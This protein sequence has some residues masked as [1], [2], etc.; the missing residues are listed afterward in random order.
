VM[1]AQLP[2][3]ASPF[4]FTNLPYDTGTAFATVGLVNT[5]STVLMGRKAIGRTPEELLGWVRANG[6]RVNLGHGGLGTSGHFCSLL[7]ARTLGIRPTFVSYRGGAPAMN[8]LLGGTL[9]LVCDQSTNAVPHIEAGGVQG[10]LV[11]GPERI[12]SIPDVPTAAELG[13]PAINL[14]VWHGLYVPRATPRPV[15][16]R[17]NAALRA[18][19]TDLAVLARFRQLG[20]APF[21]EEQRTPEAHEAMFRAEY[22]RLGRLLSEMG[23]TPGMLE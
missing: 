15:I 19:L 5:G 13:L 10:V 2:L 18:A 14:Q 3:V 23:V 9:D 21:P 8:D 20:T 22:D 6:S 4:L 11:A 16:D 12:A 17:L 7:L 1:I